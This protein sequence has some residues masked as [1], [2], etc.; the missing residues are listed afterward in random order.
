MLCYNKWSF[1]AVSK[2]TQVTAWCHA[3]PCS[4]AGPGAGCHRTPT[5]HMLKATKGIA[6]DLL[7]LDLLSPIPSLPIYTISSC[8]LVELTLPGEERKGQ[9]KEKFVTAFAAQ[10]H[11]A[12]LHK[13]LCSR[14]P[15]SFPPP[16]FPCL[17]SL[18]QPECRAGTLFR[19]SNSN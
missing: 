4:L 3:A 2:P 15:W 14:L 17:L 19:L 13:P 18:A 7:S 9:E 10:L 16:V 1:S 8:W 11:L 5:L 12:D 6:L